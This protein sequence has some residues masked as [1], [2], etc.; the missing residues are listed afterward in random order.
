M[1]LGVSKL[2]NAFLLHVLLD[3]GEKYREMLFEMMPCL[4]R[5]KKSS[6]QLSSIEN[7]SQSTESRY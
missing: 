2:F 3:V 1:T 6:T 5:K 7:S 4:T